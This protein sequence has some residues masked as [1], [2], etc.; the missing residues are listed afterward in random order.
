[1]DAGRLADAVVCAYEREELLDRGELVFKLSRLAPRQTSP[2]MRTRSCRGVPSAVSG[3]TGGPVS[4][5]RN[6]PSIL[7]QRQP[8]LGLV[9]GLFEAAVVIAAAVGA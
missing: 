3:E 7:R 8:V 2:A 5:T 1:M 6:R 9:N 4:K